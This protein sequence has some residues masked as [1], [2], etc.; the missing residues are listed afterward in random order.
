[1]CVQTNKLCSSCQDLYD[2]GRISDLDI[3]FGKV[4]MNI[5]KSLRFLSDVTIEKIIETTKTVFVVVKKGEKEKF[6]RAKDNLKKSLKVIDP[7]R[8]EFIDK[9]KN[10]KVLI[11]R[12]LSPIIPNSIST[13]FLPFSEKELKVQV[14]RTDKENINMSEEELSVL[15]NALVGMGAH[16]SYI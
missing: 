4:M 11:E 2:S 9:I 5:T 3:E 8:F 7:R 12:L 10:P 15:T 1:M 6:D 16:Y 13:V 14:K